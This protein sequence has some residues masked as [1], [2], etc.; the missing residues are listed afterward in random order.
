MGRSENS[1]NRVFEK[2]GD[3]IRTAAFDPSKMIDP[4]LIIYH[5]I[6][7]YKGRT[8][9]TNGDQTDTILDYLKQG[10]GFH[11]A[12]RT[13]EY[14][15]DEPNYTPRLS[16]LLKPNGSYTLSILKT[17]NGTPGHCLR[18]FFEYSKA[19]P[20]L[21]HYISTYETDGDPLPSFAGEPIAVN[22]A[23]TGCL[24]DYANRIWSALDKNNKVSL[25]AR[26]ITLATG[27][28]NEVI[29]NRLELL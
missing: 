12:L 1:R 9:V 15:P 14:E 2:T 17:M 11:A 6:R 13:R 20:G 5:P 10:Q 24:E 16:G 25:Y 4:S 26:E 27:E 19:I 7:V 22:I 29:I 28:A 3:G 23:D 8:I 18:C 21:G